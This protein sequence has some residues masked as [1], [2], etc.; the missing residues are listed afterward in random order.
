MSRRLRRVALDLVELRAL[1]LAVRA[2]YT[3]GDITEDELRFMEA[4]FEARGSRR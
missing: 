1:Y 4:W 2:V 3:G